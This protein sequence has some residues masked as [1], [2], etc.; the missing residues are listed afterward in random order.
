MILWTSDATHTGIDCVCE[1][2]FSPVTL[3]IHHRAGILV[4]A[5]E[6]IKDYCNQ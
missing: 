4:P 6:D 2:K 3:H 5:L 1:T